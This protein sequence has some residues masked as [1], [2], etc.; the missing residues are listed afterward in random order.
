M[1]ISRHGSCDIRIVGI[2]IVQTRVGA[3]IGFSVPRKQDDRYIVSLYYIEYR[4]LFGQVSVELSL[5]VDL[6]RQ[7]SISVV[8]FDFDCESKLLRKL[9]RRTAK[10]HP[11]VTSCTAT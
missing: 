5:S 10:N 2:H 9:L 3:N 8:A 7:L 4:G 1:D 11:C 6:N